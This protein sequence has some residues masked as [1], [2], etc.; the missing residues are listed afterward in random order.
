MEDWYDE[1]RSDMIKRIDDRLQHELLGVECICNLFESAIKESR[2]VRHEILFVDD[3]FYLNPEN[4]LCPTSPPPQPFPLLEPEDL[5]A[6]TV[7]NLETIVTQLITICPDRR[8]SVFA[9]SNWLKNSVKY[10][11]RIK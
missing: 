3:H 10:F 2:T 6:I 5:F 9:L 4:V 11:P 7:Y 1:C 8:I